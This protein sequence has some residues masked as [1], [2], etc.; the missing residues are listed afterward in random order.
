MPNNFIILE[1]DT[2]VCMDLE[3]MLAARYPGGCVVQ[4]SSLSEL[5][6]A[7]HNCGP[8]TVLVIRGTLL[9]SSDDV[10]RVVRT[11]ATRGSHIVIIGQEETVEFPATFVDLPFTTEM[12]FA[13]VDPRA[14]FDSC[15][16]PEVTR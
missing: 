8:D 5:G 7:I 4:G 6:P 12:M 2:I 14:E 15:D 11:V 13:A 10:R 16:R 3:G 9:F 1:P